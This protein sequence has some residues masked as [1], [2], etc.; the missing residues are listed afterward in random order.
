MY[1][2]QKMES[3]EGDGR[4]DGQKHLTHYY[5]INYKQFVNV[6]KYRVDHMRR[7]LELE[8]KKVRGAEESRG[9]RGV[10]EGGNEGKEG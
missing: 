4:A 7:R 3:E 1:S 5:F 2:M 10:K 6:V 9:E 8:E